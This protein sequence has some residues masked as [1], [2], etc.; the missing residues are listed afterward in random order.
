M[1]NLLDA[2]EKSTVK[3]ISIDCGRI[4]SRRLRELGMYEGT[5][6]EVLKND[7]FGPVIIKVKGSK[8][9]IGRGQAYKI[10]VE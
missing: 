5:E 8:F 2:A 9:A 3:I 4:L 1:K 7:N 10:K 6:I